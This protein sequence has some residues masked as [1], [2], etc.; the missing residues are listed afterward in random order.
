ML[1]RS[2]IISPQS[3][4]ESRQGHSERRH[5]GGSETVCTEGIEKRC[6]WKCRSCLASKL[7]SGGEESGK[8]SWGGSSEVRAQA[9]PSNR[10]P[11]GILKSSTWCQLWNSNSTEE[12]EQF[13]E[14]EW[15]ICH[16]KWSSIR[17]AVIPANVKM[18][19]ASR[20]GTQKEGCVKSNLQVQLS[21]DVKSA[22]SRFS[23]E[24]T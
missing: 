21:H 14:A 6:L 1:W 8:V 24:K 13:R 10:D 2:Q 11:W 23:Q 12:S 22:L 7:S 19:Q 9:F 15:H 20:T 5:L 3:Q 17:T 16:W 4:G 18:A